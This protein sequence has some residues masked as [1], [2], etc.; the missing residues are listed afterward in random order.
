M[1]DFWKITG[2]LKYFDPAK[3]F[4]FISLDSDNSEVFFHY[5]DINDKILT[6]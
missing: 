6:K 4:G 3:T 1:D 5:D 2:T